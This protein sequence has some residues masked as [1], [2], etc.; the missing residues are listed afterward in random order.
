M[1]RFWII[2][3]LLIVV[4]GG[5]FGMLWHFVSSLESKIEVDGGVL[6]WDVAGNY[7]EERDDSFWGQ[8]RGGGA[9]TL[10]ELVFSLHRAADD[11]R[12]TSLVM[13]V[14]GL[15]ADWAKVEEMRH[16]IEAFKASG[17]TVT[18]YLDM[19]GTRAKLA[20]PLPTFL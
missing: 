7:A 19:A 18:A 11:D 17:K 14:Q 20:V 5:G 12:I 8:V 16:A 6:L 9:M 15:G 10:S 4:I 3:G 13:N 2:F 1:K